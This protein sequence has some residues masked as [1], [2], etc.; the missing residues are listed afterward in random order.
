MPKKKDNGCSHEYPHED[1][2]TARDLQNQQASYKTYSTGSPMLDLAIGRKDP[3]TGR[4]GIPERAIVEVFGKNSSCKCFGIDTPILMYD[5]T[6]KAVQDII[7]GD[8]LMGPDSKPREVTDLIRGI[9]DLYEVIPKRGKPWVCNGNHI[10]SLKTSGLTTESHRVK[11]QKQRTRINSKGDVINITVNDFLEKYKARK[12]LFSL[13]KSNCVTF[14]PGYSIVPLDPYF[15]GLWLG[16]GHS[17]GPAITTMDEE[18]LQ[19]VTD[20]AELNGLFIR[21]EERKGLA[22]TYNMSSGRIGPKNR[23][24]IKEELKS[25]NL[26]K[27]K[28]I[29]EAYLKASQQIRLQLLAGLLDTDGGLTKNKT[30]FNIIQKSK[31]LAEDIA[32]LAASLGFGTSIHP[33][34]RGCMYKGE[35]RG[36]IYHN[37][38]ISGSLESIPTRLPNKRGVTKELIRDTLVTGFDLKYLGK[39]NIYGFSVSGPD[40]LFLLG[41][42]TVVHNSALMES[43]MKNVL[44]DD[45]ENLVYCIFGEEP[46]TE[47][48]EALGIDLDRVIALFC[49]EDGEVKKQLAER[50]MEATKQAVQDPRVKLVVIDSLKSLC[51]VKQLYTDKGEIHELDMKEQLGIKAKMITDY[52]RDFKQLNKR[53]ILFMVNQLSDR[54]EIGPYAHLQNPRYTPETP[55]G[56]GKEFECTLRI[57]NQVSPLES[58]KPHPLTQSKILLGW[59]VNFRLVKNKYSNKSAGRTAKSEFYFDPPG[60]SS[61]KEIFNI[62][63]Y[64]GIIPKI[65]ARIYQIGDQKLN[66]KKAAIA[67][68]RQNKAL[69]D[70]V[71]GEVHA[72][73][74]ELFTIPEDDEEELI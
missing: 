30:N 19:Y 24:P 74:E 31:K 34:N 58:T 23:N 62:A 47:R 18:I 9:D 14:D 73:G 70:K 46:E 27:N 21:T 66:G 2:K 1:H 8:L 41:D 20:Y 43:L 54:I 44:D 59:E 65:S 12:N 33:Y 51:S 69:V 28:H 7:E 56:R 67:A 49:Y 52:I 37:V 42:F 35:W 40:Q 53:A 6:V 57:Q 72:R 17:G 71:A 64:L 45:P 36:G 48:M 29:P 63:E 50:H 60:F 16:D 10:L 61:E 39:G 22:A 3:K 25:L 26:I 13:Y 38:R 15:L 32:F 68:F 4:A 5:G 11:G 55:G